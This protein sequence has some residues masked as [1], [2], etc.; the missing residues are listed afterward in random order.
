MRSTGQ[1]TPADGSA[2]NSELSPTYRLQPLNFAK[3]H[4]KVKAMMTPLLR[5]PLAARR[6]TRVLGTPT[7]VA[8]P[9]STGS[10]LTKGMAIG[11]TLSVTVFAA[12][13]AL[14]QTCDRAEFET[15]VT[16]ASA[17]LRD[18]T[19]DKKPAF[20]E[21]LRGLMAKRGWTYDQFVKE[22]GPIVADD[23]VTAYDQ[24]SADLLAKINRMGET[25]R[26]E[27]APDCA[28]L[29]EL[30]STMT[31]LITTQTEKWSYLFAKLDAESAR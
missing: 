24:A 5:A 17:T 2:L 4:G 9:F 30:R 14:A 11:M 8:H 10:F 18:L 20:Q 13:D 28:M 19:A 25:G 27:A 23:K 12:S 22:A 7:A 29:N 3:R 26:N 21:K 6:S 31:A 15:V 1:G 16:S